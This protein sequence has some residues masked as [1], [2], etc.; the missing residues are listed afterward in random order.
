MAPKLVA[1]ALPV[2]VERK[3]FSKSTKPPG[4]KSAPPIRKESG[5]SLAGSCMSLATALVVAGVL[6]RRE[7]SSTCGVPAVFASSAFCNVS[8]CCC[9]W[10]ICCCCWAM[11]SRNA[12]NSEAIDVGSDGAF[13]AVV[14]AQTNPGASTSKQILDNHLIDAL[15]SLLIVFTENVVHDPRCPVL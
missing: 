14:W 11:A 12:F 9:C 5:D 15:S 7:A 6:V 2:L 8:I 13:C 1:A 4:V 10:A 3:M